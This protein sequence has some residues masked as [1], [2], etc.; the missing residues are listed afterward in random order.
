V[1]I[2]KAY[3]IRGVYPDELDE[4]L[5]KKI[6]NAFAVHIGKGPIVV[7]RDMRTSSP[8]ISA[9]VIDGVTDAGV[10]V[11]D[12]GL[13]TT[14]M[15]YFA[16]GHLD[17]AG[18]VMTT[19]SHNPG[20]YNGFKVSREK[21]IPLAYETGI[22]ELE[23]I[24]TSGEYKKADSKGKVEKRD[25]L[26]DYIDHVLEIAGE[27]K[28]LRLAIDAGNGITGAFLPALLERLP[29][30]VAQMYFTPDGTFPNHEANPL[31]PEN[32][33][34]LQAKVKEIGADLGIA[35]DGDG[36]RC[37]FVDE[38]GETVSSDM[39]TALIAKEVLKRNPGAGIL[40]DL[41]S[42]HAVPEEITANGGRPVRSRVGHA[43]M[44]SILR[45][46]DMPFGGELSGHY[47]FRDN[48]YADSGFM[49]MVKVLTLLSESGVPFSEMI[50]PLKRYYA[51]G[52]VNFTVED[53]DA[54]IAEIA[55]KFPDGEIDYLDG[56]TVSYERWWF[57]VRKSNTEPMLRLNLEAD[58]PEL[59]EEMAGKVKA[60]LSGG[61]A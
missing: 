17:A 1:G 50:R 57:N 11:L 40:Y 34:D 37:A 55:E 47:Y 21:A 24:V 27:I 26:R 15:S 22:N 38:K 4:D 12:I 13:C 58:T 48:Y 46:Q 25:V 23:R 39:V 29:C 3:D 41:R 53:K 61:Q 60:I 10:D 32:V 45:E 7:G 43:Y 30:E 56:I 35:F 59:R 20:K 54:K 51:T 14:P 36:D 16:I 9:A 44:K 49:A 28:P 2:F 5:A 33:A 6:G 52:E 31:K 18:G 19:A 42:S 8:S